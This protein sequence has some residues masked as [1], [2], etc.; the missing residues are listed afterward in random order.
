[1][2]SRPSEYGLAIGLDQTVEAGPG[3]LDT[4]DLKADYPASAL[5]HMATALCDVRFT[6]VVSTG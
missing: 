3:G 4:I 6:P 5:G 2:R 1:M